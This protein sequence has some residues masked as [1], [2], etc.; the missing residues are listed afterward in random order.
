M[1]SVSSMAEV[2]IPPSSRVFRA[3]TADPVSSS[4]KAKKFPKSGGGDSVPLVRVAS[5][6]ISIVH[7]RAAGRAGVGADNF[8]GHNRGSH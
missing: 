8:A 6:K 4:P 7:L 1:V 5:R 2:R 3:Q